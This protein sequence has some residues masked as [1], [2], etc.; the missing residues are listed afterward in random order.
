M[1]TAE[2]FIINKMKN[3]P[4]GTPPTP[5]DVENWLYEFSEMRLEEPLKLLERAKDLV[6]NPGTNIS[7]STD[8]ACE[9]WQ[10]D[11]EEWKS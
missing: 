8:I 7:A 5:K 11:Y 2:I 10:K 1:I 9:N 6:G 4:N 3:Y